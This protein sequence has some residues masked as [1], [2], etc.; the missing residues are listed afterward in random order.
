M[1]K[2]DAIL[3]LENCINTFLHE[4]TDNEEE[5]SC[6]AMREIGECFLCEEYKPVPEALA[7]L[8]KLKGGVK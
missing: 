8:R 2:A 3:I 1:N 7:Y 5:S 4:H 6:D